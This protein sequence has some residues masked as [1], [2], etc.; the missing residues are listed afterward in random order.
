MN[1]YHIIT[2]LVVL[3]A[4]FAYLNKRF[5]KLPISIGLMF[6]GTVLS[7][8]LIIYSNIF[9]NSVSHIKEFIDGLDFSKIVLDILL[10][11]LLFAGAMHTDYNQLKENKRSIILF[12]FV[13]VIISTFLVAGILYSISYLVGY[14][15]NFLYCLLF[16][17][18]ISPTDPIAVLGIL[19]KAN[20]PKSAE[21]NIVGESL[22]NDGIGVVVFVTLLSI[23]NLGVDNVGVADVVLIF[24]EEA[25]GGVLLG[26]LLGYLIFLVLRSIDD[27][28]TEVI[29]TLAAVMGGTWLAQSLHFSGP[30][31]MVVAGLMTG[32]KSKKEAMSD[33]TQLF[34]DKFWH[35]IDVLMNALLFALMGLKFVSI[36]FN[37]SYLLIAVIAM[38]FFIL[39]R[40]LSLLLPYLISR[41]W[42][43][44]S[45]QTILL[46]TWGGLRGGLS[47]AMVLSL[48]ESIE[49]KNMFVLITYVVVM[50]SIFI[51]GMTVEKFAKRVYKEE[52]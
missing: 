48:S 41:K 22:F 28:E 14:Q 11:F 12:A 9:P 3:S 31:A 17:A 33:N 19:K 40:Y 1:L 44:V 24:V 13:S 29:V 35:L 6:L 36:D 18:L 43:D 46:M 49:S 37:Y 42:L 16:G 25:G 27:Y 51:Q 47:I 52:V 45:K 4:T 8:L 23:I 30:L 34:V 5:I 50:F 10:S 39:A 7:I 20:V 2:S 26:L 32:H 15:L 21:I 38:P